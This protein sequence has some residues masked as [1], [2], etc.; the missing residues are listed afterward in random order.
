MSIR[1][2]RRR[3]F[4]ESSPLEISLA[5]IIGIIFVFSGLYLSFLPS[6]F[7]QEK[8]AP[9]S[10]LLVKLFRK[11]DVG[12]LNQVLFPQDIV[13]TYGIKPWLLK[14]LRGP[15]IMV[16]RGSLSALKKEIEKARKFSLSIDYLNYNPEH[17][18]ESHTPQEEIEDLV[19]AVREARKLAEGMGAKLSF[20]TDHVLLERYG[21]R[22]APLVDLFGVQMQRY[23][24]E[25]L[26]DFRQE[27][28]K[29][30]R[31]IRKGS[32]S[33]PVFFQLSLSPPL[34]KTV[35]LPGGKRKRV[36]L[37]KEGKKVTRPLE[38]EE[39]LH[40]IKAIRDLADGIALIYS[41]ETRE[42]MREVLR[43]LRKSSSFS[44]SGIKNQ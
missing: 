34:W 16:T 35:I 32:R 42:E 24:R 20:I 15:Q 43:V 18:K 7:S 30:L 13:A 21:Q 14:D 9:S 33:V 28:I 1:G 25:S 40:Q 22:I 29:K 11:E 2:Q 5:R 17:W 26:E 36:H 31:I 37:R 12:F 19:R 8:D 44:G 23:Q 4:P 38:L 27:A 6:C 41:E 10:H 39:I 3:R